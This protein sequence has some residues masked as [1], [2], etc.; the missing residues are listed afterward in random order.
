[1]DDLDRKDLAEVSWWLEQLGSWSLRASRDS[2]SG[3][4]SG[5]PR[6]AT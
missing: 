6:R 5:K 3:Q 4:D 1:M 2:P